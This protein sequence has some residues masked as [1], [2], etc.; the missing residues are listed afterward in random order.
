MPKGYRI[1]KNK[2][3]KILTRNTSKDGK[4]KK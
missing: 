2:K 1:K 4:A 3:E